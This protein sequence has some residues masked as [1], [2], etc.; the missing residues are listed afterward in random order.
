MV[1]LNVVHRA[2]DSQK[3]EQKQHSIRHVTLNACF[4]TGSDFI[5]LTIKSHTNPYLTFEETC[6]EAPGDETKRNVSESCMSL[7]VDL[8]SL[9]HSKWRA[10]TILNL[11]NLAKTL[12]TRLIGFTF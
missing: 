7:C 10:S 12:R 9:Q 8:Q 6:C 11:A 4:Y 5:E 2:R 1:C 3:T